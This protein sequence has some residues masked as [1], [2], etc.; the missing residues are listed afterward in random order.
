MSTPAATSGPASEP[1]PASSAPA[2]NRAPRERSKRKSFAAR[3]RRARVRRFAAPGA[4]GA[5]ALAAAVVARAIASMMN[6]RPGGF[7]RVSA[8]P[9]GSPRKDRNFSRGLEE[10]DPVGRPVGEEGLADD[11]AAWDGSPEAAVVARAA[12]VAHHEV[13]V[14]R[15]RDRLGHGAARPA[16]TRPDEGLLRLH[17]VDDRV[18]VLDRERVPRPGHD[19]LDEVG[20]RLLVDR[21]R[22]GLVPTRLG[23]ALRVSVDRSLGRVEDHDVPDLGVAEVIADSVDE[24]TLADVQRRLHRC[25]GDLVGLDDEGLY[26][27]RQANR[28]RDDHD[29]LDEGPAARR[30][31][32]NQR[33]QPPVRASSAFSPS[34]SSASSSDSPDES[35]PATPSSSAVTSAPSPADVS[36]EASSPPSLSSSSASTTSGSASLWATPSESTASVSSA[37]STRSSSIPQRRSATRARLPTR[38]RR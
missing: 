6:N 30:G 1:R 31:F 19:P 35:A 29:E 4:T 34:A 18:A 20:V 15:D 28:E 22:A 8:Q 21:L 25:G 37:A 23:A 12:V 2:T 17:P 24:H 9:P 5:S 14:G 11:P 27:E 7:R 38:P 36:S 26:Q 32:R 16:A 3:L 13:V 10:P 33:A